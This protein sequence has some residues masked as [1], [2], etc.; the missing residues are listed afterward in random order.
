MSLYQIDRPRSAKFIGKFKFNYQVTFGKEFFG[1]TRVPQP[2]FDTNAV[3][4]F[5]INE[6][7]GLRA[8][9]GVSFKNSDLGSF[10]N[11]PGQLP[12]FGPNEYDSNAKQVLVR[13]A[14]ELYPGNDVP[15]R[16]YIEIDRAS[17]I[18][19]SGQ[20]VSLT[21]TVEGYVFWGAVANEFVDI[22]EYY[23]SKDLIL[24]LVKS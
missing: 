15:Q 2:F 24:L 3:V 22:Q 12:N 6:N 23:P 4:R 7:E 19:N 16:D 8:L 17:F 20:T 1:G 10:F 9:V 13:I 18:P 11:Y 21:G 5:T 14:Y